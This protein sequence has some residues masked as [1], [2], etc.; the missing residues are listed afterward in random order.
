MTGDSMPLRDAG[1]NL[2][3]ARAGPANRPAGVRPPGAPA[4]PDPGEAAE[5]AMPARG[6]A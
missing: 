5:N 4:G 2:P 1:L 3:A 6:G